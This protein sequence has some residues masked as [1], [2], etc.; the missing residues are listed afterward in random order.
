[1]TFGFVPLRIR[2]HNQPEIKN[3][4]GEIFYSKLRPYIVWSGWKSVER[5]FSSS[6]HCNLT[7]FPTL[8]LSISDFLPRKIA[9]I[10]DNSFPPEHAHQCIFTMKRV[11]NSLILDVP[12]IGVRKKKKSNLFYCP[13]YDSL[14]SAAISEGSFTHY[15]RMNSPRGRLN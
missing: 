5:G 8:L 10:I 7:K 13:I 11:I 2:L 6:N 4:E 3:G 14:S 15:I 1:M 12:E 9:S